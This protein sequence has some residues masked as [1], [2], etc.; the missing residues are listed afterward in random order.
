[1]FEKKAKKVFTK[2]NK[3]IFFLALAIALGIY[4][5]FKLIEVLIFVIF[6][7]TILNP[8]AIRYLII[9]AFG[10]LMLAAVFL[11][12]DQRIQAEQAAVYAFYFLIMVAFMGIHEIRKNHA[13]SDE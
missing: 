13:Q 9:P 10:L 12:F 3:S 5:D 6:I 7:W 2:R 1:M 8:V 11:I 4:L